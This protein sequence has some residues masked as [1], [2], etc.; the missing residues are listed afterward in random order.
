MAN[1]VQTFHVH[2]GMTQSIKMQ[3]GVCDEE[4][5]TDNDLNDHH[6]LCEIFL[7]SNI[8]CKDN[9]ENLTDLKEHINLEHRKISPSDYR[10]CYW[11]MNTKD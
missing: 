8:H 10:F 3:C 5:N 1:E 4:F 11:I 9:F 7:C 2:F 6:S